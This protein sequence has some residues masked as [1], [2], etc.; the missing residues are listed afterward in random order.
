MK[1]AELEA[2]HD[3]YAESELTIEKMVNDHEFPTVLSFC[4]ESFP[5]I[6]PAINYRKKKN[7][8]LNT[9]DPLAIT[10]ICKYAPPLFEHAAIESLAEF[11]KSTR[12]LA[13][14]EKGYL[15]SIDAARKREQHA[16]KL[17]SCLEKRPETLQCNIHKELGVIHEDTIEIVELWEVLGVIDKEPEARSYRLRFRTQLD[18]EIEGR[19]QSCGV[20]G[21]GQKESFLKPVTCQKCGAKGY[22][23]IE[24]R[25]PQ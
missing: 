18:K 12:I 6:V 4:V 17:W 3:A 24:Y 7:F 2:H 15:S 5:H 16:H 20:R 11:I 8:A 23:H 9:F 19:C 22:Y 13:S 25:D 10:T 1:I 21:K 14:S